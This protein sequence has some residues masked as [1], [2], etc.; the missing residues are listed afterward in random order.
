MGKSVYEQIKEGRSER[1]TK[2]VSV[3]D[4]FENKNS[5]VVSINEEREKAREL[6]S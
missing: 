5:R 1:L 4:Q 2:S 3:S 6:G